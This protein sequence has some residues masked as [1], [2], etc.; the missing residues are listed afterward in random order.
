MDA[1][2]Q[3]LRWAWL[4][5]D[6]VIDCG[7]VAQ[8]LGPKDQRESENAGDCDEPVARHGGIE[9]NPALKALDLHTQLHHLRTIQRLCFAKSIYPLM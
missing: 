2:S 7:A 8:F 9:K 3:V 4:L 1:R 5:A 6:D